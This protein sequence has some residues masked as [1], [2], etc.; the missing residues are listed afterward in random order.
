[1]MDHDRIIV[2]DGG[3]VMEFDHPWK[4]LQMEGGMFKSMCEAAVDKDNLLAL[5]KAAWETFDS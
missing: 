5:A 4:L 2:L 1:M 3:K